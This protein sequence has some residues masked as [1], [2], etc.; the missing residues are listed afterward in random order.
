[1]EPGSAGALNGKTQRKIPEVICATM[2]QCAFPEGTFDAVTLFDVVEHI[3]DDAGF[4]AQ[5]GNVLT[6]DG[7]VFI[8]VPAH[9]WMWSS[10]DDSAQHYRRYNRATML[11]ALEGAVQAGVFHVFLRAAGFAHPDAEVFTVS[12]PTWKT[13]TSQCVAGRA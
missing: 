12:V 8:T 7:L 1:M 13:G 3:E 10:S 11:R 2:E 6:K 5:V 9:Q 4:L